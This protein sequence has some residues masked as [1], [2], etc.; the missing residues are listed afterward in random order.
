MG[1]GGGL[2]VGGGGGQGRRGEGSCN[3]TINFFKIFGWKIKIGQL[4]G[5]PVVPAT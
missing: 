4:I 3:G 2:T 1:R 5:T